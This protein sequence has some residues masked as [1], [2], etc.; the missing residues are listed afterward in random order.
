MT[1]LPF[2]GVFVFRLTKKYMGYQYRF[3]NKNGLL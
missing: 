1:D 2:A 3:L